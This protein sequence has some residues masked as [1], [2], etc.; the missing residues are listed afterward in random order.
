VGLGL[1]LA[2]S[3]SYTDY[4]QSLG[5]IFSQGASELSLNGAQIAAFQLLGSATDAGY[6]IIENGLAGIGQI[7]G[8]EFGLHQAYFTRLS[9]VS[10]VVAAMPEV[11]DILRTEQDPV[12]G[13]SAAIQRR[14]ASGLLTPG[15]LDMAGKVYERLCQL[16][17]DELAELQDLLTNGKLTMGDAARM[18]RVRAID[19]KVR[20]QWRAGKEL[21]GEVEGLMGERKQEKAELPSRPLAGVK[22]PYSTLTDWVRISYS[23]WRHVNVDFCNP[24]RSSIKIV[25][26]GI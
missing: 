7:H 10:P 26:K 21:A 15:E 19:A 2:C 12:S 6:N 24:N 8:T 17:T 1:L 9:A 14:R 4:A 11:P 18:K 16:G 13:L 3:F 20:E 23:S 22:L 25:P 5:E